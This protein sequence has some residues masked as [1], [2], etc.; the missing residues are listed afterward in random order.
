MKTYIFAIILGLF[1]LSG[2][3]Q[4]EGELTDSWS[5]D[6]MS[7]SETINASWSLD[8]NIDEPENNEEDNEDIQEDRDA[9]DEDTEIKVEVSASG[10]AQATDEET[11]QAI[12]DGLSDL[13]DILTEEIINEIF[14]NAE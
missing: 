14:W 1:I 9:S 13:E 8:N 6:T 3:F 2:C 5:L 11:Q 10:S 4:K 7:G 12:D